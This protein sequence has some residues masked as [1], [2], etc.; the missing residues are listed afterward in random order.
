MMTLA[1]KESGVCQE[2]GQDMPIGTRAR[3]YNREKIYHEGACPDTS[4]PPVPS[5]NGQKD[6]PSMAQLRESI[7][8]QRSILDAAELQ[9]D[10]L[11]I[12]SPQ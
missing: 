11:E 7:W 2:C 1:L 12:E 5:D 9:L 3:Y 10:V 4:E 8:I 6:R